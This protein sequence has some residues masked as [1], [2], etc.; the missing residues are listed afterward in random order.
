MFD[1]IAGQRIPVCVMLGV[2]TCRPW[3]WMFGVRRSTFSV[4]VQRNQRHA[5][6]RTLARLV[7]PDPRMH[8]AGVEC[9]GRTGGWCRRLFVLVVFVLGNRMADCSEHNSIH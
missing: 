9:P 6:L 5:A 2:L 7:A 1:V 3:R 4:F 8:R